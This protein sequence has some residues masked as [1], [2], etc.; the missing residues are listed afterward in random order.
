MFPLVS[1]L[2]E[3]SDMNKCM[4]CPCGADVDWNECPYHVHSGKYIIH[5]KA[6][7]C[8]FWCEGDSALDAQ[9]KWE[10]REIYS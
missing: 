3:T 9:Q 5:C 1:M 7:D 4:K 2:K 8:G 10:K 6:D